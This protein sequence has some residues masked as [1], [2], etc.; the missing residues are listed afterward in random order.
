M[1]DLQQAG[2]AEEITTAYDDLVIYELVSMTTGET[3]SRESKLRVEVE[4]LPAD[5]VILTGNYAGPPTG[6]HF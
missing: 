5:A 1:S 6:Q 4:F 2:I 3:L